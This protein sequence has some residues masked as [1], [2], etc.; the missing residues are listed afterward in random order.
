MMLRENRVVWF[1]SESKRRETCFDQFR[2][3]RETNVNGEA[4]LDWSHLE[5]VGSKYREWPKTSRM[6]SWYELPVLLL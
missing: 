6:K 5:K 3:G 1:L 4:R 2:G